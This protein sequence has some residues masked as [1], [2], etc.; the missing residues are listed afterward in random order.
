MGNALYLVENLTV[1]LESL[2]YILLYF[3]FVAKSTKFNK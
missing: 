1:F 2:T 3:K